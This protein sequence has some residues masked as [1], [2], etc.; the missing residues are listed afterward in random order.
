MNSDR[1]T[2]GHVIA[3]TL[4]L[5]FTAGALFPV[6]FWVYYKYLKQTKEDITNV[7]GT[8]IENQK[9]LNEKLKKELEGKDE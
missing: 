9:L 4:L 8:H 3:A 1:Y 6:S 7:V 5:V 2:L